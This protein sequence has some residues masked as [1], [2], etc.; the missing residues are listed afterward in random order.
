MSNR[1]DTVH[2]KVVQAADVHG[3]VVLVDVNL[4]PT[5]PAP[6]PRQ[7]P[8]Q[9]KDFTG[10]AS[11]VEALNSLLLGPGMSPPVLL[12][13][14][15]GVGKTTLAVHW[16]HSSGE[17]FPDG[18]LYAD[19]HGF[20]P[21]QVETASIQVLKRFLK[22]LGTRPEFLPDDL[23]GCAAA[24]RTLLADRKVLVVLDNVGSA[25]QVRPLLTASTKCRLLL[26]SRTR[27]AG[28]DIERLPVEVFSSAESD[29]LL[30]RILGAE[31]VDEEPAVAV[32]IALQC[33][34]LPLALRVAAERLRHRPHYT[35]ADLSAE[36]DDE[37][38]SALELPGD[39]LMAVGPAISLS[40]RSL[41][42]CSAKVFRLLG[43]QACADS[44]EQAVVALTRLEPRQVRKSLAFLL[45]AHLLEEVEHGRYRFHDLLRAYARQQAAE[46]DS[47]EDRFAAILGLT[48]WYASM[49]DHADR[50]LAGHRARRHL[51]LREDAH[52]VEFASHD[53][54]M[55]WCDAEL[56]NIESCLEQA[57]PLG[58]R[59]LVWQVPA[60]LQGFFNLTK[61]LS[62]W[63][64]SHGLGLAAATAGNDLAGTALMHHG[65][66][67]GYRYRQ[68]DE[69]AVIHGVRALDG[70]RELGDRRFQG[71]VLS[72]L[73]LSYF[74]LGQYDEAH[75]RLEESLRAAQEV[76][77]RH[78]EAWALTNLGSVHRRQ[79]EFGKSLERLL[80]AVRIRDEIG[81]LDGEAWTRD[82]LGRT[83]ANLGRSEDAVEAFD[84]AIDLH[85]ANSNVYGL[86]RVLHHLALHL[87][88]TG[89]EERARAAGAEALQIFDRLGSSDASALRLL[90]AALDQVRTGT[91]LR[92]DDLRS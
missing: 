61:H 58:L 34:R 4:H 68:D 50:T 5:V 25:A 44:S 42:P 10:R 70:F 3:D 46:V 18:L 81:D 53:E 21:D 9:S 89:Q 83:C 62:V 86:A 84:R 74:C 77:D 64:D 23:D 32:R 56:V 63:C 29:G 33:A 48:T 73:G 88:G 85:R 55:K 37:R 20:T 43:V 30:R 12:T 24:Y 67:C 54:A 17:S 91:P 66:A 8:L 59:D 45:D 47:T 36:L 14:S 38:L 71:I 87:V 75:E 92:P 79:D 40:Y 90:L 1:I 76:G 22:A 78:A 31:R 41:D 6:V 49:A 28:L 57:H 16:A 60:A 35:L 7:L 26:T 11:H 82:E 13:G 27:L 69:K 15:A 19:L 2:G 65:L 39:V 72:N 80:L 51:D 52:K